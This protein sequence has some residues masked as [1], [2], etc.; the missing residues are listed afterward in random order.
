MMKVVI[1][2]GRR[3]LTNRRYAI[4]DD[5]GLLEYLSAAGCRADVDKLA[6]DSRREIVPG[7][8]KKP[9]TMPGAFELT[10]LSQN[11]SI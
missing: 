2:I 3:A 4:T 7:A 10:K 5:S 1:F 8:Q 11:I 6:G 9:R